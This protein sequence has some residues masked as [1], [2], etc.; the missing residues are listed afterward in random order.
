MITTE[1]EKEGK[2]TNEIRSREIGRNIDY[3]YEDA[4]IQLVH[5]KLPTEELNTSFLW[6]VKTNESYLDFFVFVFHLKNIPLYLIVLKT[7]G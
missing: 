6:R 4:E 2:F 5:I 7:K 3:K 1:M